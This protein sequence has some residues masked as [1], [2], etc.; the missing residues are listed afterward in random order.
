MNN[1]Y[2][3]KVAALS[4]AEEEAHA[5]RM[6]AGMAATISGGMGY[7]AGRGPAAKA[8]T[9]KARRD[10]FSR[11]IDG[12]INA[13]ARKA[14]HH[15]NNA[16]N[17]ALS[18]ADALYHGLSTQEQAGKAINGLKVKGSVNNKYGKAISRLTAR[19]R[20]LKAGGG[21]LAAA[22]VLSMVGS[23]RGYNAKVKQTRLSKE[24]GL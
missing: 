19:S 15:A 7:M 2:L 11:R 18:Q 3:E 10:Q 6:G 8:N 23:Q 1:V 24:E 14:F 16:A 20:V 4:D 9:L 17:P 21:A 13:Y 22:G 5:N 12:K